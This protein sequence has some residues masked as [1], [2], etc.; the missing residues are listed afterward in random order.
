MKGLRLRGELDY[1]DAKF[2]AIIKILNRMGY[3]YLEISALYRF[4]QVDAD[5]LIDAIWK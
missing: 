5:S 3:F 4:I 1:H 2:P